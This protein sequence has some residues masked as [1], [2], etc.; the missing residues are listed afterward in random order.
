[1]SHVRATGGIASPRDYRD[2]YV[3]A[4]MADIAPDVALPA[5]FRSEIPG[6]VLDQNQ[7][8]SCV[9]HAWALAMRK[10]WFEKHGEVVDFSPR[11]LDVLVKRF[12]GLGG[13]D[14]RDSAGTYPRLVCKLAAQYGC[15]T[16]KTVPNLTEQPTHAYRDDDVLTEAA[17]A[18]AKK[19]RI[20]GYVRIGT[21]RGSLRLGAYLYG[22]VST[23]MLI[24]SEWW[25]P[26][27][28]ARDIDPLRTPNPQVSGHQVVT[29]GWEGDA[30]EWLQNSW[31]TMWDLLGFAHYNA[32]KWAPFLV[33]AWAI[34]QIPKDTADFLKTLPAPSAFQYHF[35]KDVH[36]GDES[37]EVKFVQIALMIL[38][39]LAPI[40]AGELGIYGGKTAN[41][42]ER[43]QRAHGI[44]KPSANDVGPQTRGQLNSIFWT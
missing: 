28:D 35:E 23:L 15:A 9:S 22:A 37:E 7:T 29:V 18:E 6:E 13:P 36:R 12:D 30:L 33:E 26:S 24:G 43:F 14:T 44:K 38:G 39:Y 4:A 31:S 25:V 20:P 34:A 10:W 2:A 40:P 27:W 5:S 11:F 16:T 21:D 1:M 17:F 8:P 42:V 19:Y 41:A 32:A 3:A